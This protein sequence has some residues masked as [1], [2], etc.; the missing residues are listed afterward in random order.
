MAPQTTDAALV[1]YSLT[2]SGNFSATG[3]IEFDD[4][5]GSGPADPDFAD[6]SMTLTNLAGTAGLPFTFM[7]SMVTAIDWAIDPITSALQMD[8]DVA[9][10]TVGTSQYDISLDSIPPFNTSVTCG[11]ANLLGPSAAACTTIDTRTALTTGSFTATRIAVPAPGTLVLFVAVLLG[12][13][14]LRSGRSPA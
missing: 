12:F 8:L 4:L 10:Q 7:K 5:I 1:E 11:P 13:T 2:V 3:T 6:F 14:V 9:T